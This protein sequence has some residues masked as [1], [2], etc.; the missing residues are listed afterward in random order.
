MLIFKS[1]QKQ[2]RMIKIDIKIIEEEVLKKLNFIENTS[3]E[4]YN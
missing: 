4:N 2:K 1:K 3:N